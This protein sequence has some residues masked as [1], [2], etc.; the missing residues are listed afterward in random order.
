MFI[1]QK[2]NANKW[3]VLTRMAGS[4]W[5][6]VENRRLFAGSASGRTS[7]QHLFDADWDTCIAACAN[8]HNWTRLVPMG[9][10]SQWGL[11]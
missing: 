9:I 2:M 6:T 7:C 11:R 8:F 3:R 5:T 4:L 1:T 10:S